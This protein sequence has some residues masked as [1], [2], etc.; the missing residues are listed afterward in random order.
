MMMIIHVV[1]IM[2]QE[3]AGVMEHHQAAVEG[4]LKET[5]HHYLIH[6]EEEEESCLP[7]VLTPQEDL[8]HAHHCLKGLQLHLDIGDHPLHHPGVDGRRLR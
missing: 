4:V 6:Q 1:E 2:N 5:L 3:V 7:N 8:V